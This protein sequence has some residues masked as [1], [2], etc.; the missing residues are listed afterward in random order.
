MNAFSR[1]RY[2]CYPER[3]VWM[4]PR[5]EG[6]DAVIAVCHNSK[7]KYLSSLQSCP[8]V[9]ARASFSVLLSWTCLGPVLLPK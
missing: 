5:E 7:V 1:E 2:G 9:G 3:K 8:R 6:M 4:L